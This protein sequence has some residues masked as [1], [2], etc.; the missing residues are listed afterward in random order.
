MRKKRYPR[1]ESLY[2]LAQTN[3]V[4]V[5]LNYLPKIVMKAVNGKTLW[6]GEGRPPADLFDI[7][8]ALSIQRYTQMSTRR[9]MGMIYILCKFAQ[10]H[11]EMPSW[12]TLC[13]YRNNAS[14][15]HF[16]DSMIEET[17]SPLKLLERDFSTDMTG[18]RTSCFSSWF[19]L[20]TKKRIRHRDH[21]ASHVTTSRILNAAVAVDVNV[22]KGKDSFYMRQHV[23]R[24]H[25]NFLINDWCGDSA[26]LARA[27]CKAVSSEG[28][29]PWFHL[30][31]NTRD[32]ADGSMAW[33]KMVIALRTSEEAQKRYHKRSNSEST[34]GAKKRKFGDFVRSKQ[35]AA[36]ENEEHLGWVVYN[37]PVLS[38]AKYEH[39]IIPKF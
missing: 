15:K 24:V 33:K 34:F 30:K 8:V 21:I 2:N 22:K 26:Y 23:E 3:E 31:K 1:D 28:G 10:I 27:N 37:F 13:R 7:L 39:G 4:F 32:K 19:S 16:L 17:S 25:K 14:I 6:K 9:S 12:R 29:T 38:R 11:I 5:F 36:K 20:R 35:D 18:S